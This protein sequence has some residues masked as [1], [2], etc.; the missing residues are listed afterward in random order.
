MK[1]SRDPAFQGA[2]GS[3]RFS[4]IVSSFVFVAAMAAT[5]GTAAAQAVDC[6]RLQAQIASLGRGGGGDPARVQ[7]FQR[8]AQSQQAELDRTV[9]YSR[10]IGCGRRQFLFFGDAA[11]PQCGGLEQQI[12]RMQVNLDQLR[13]QMQRASG[14]DDAQRRDLTARFDAY[15]RGGQP[16]Q[17]AG[18]GLFDTLFGG[19]NS[20]RDVPLEDPSEMPPEDTAPR[21]GSLAICVKTCDG[22]FFPVSYS[23]NRARM[24]EL[25]DLCHALCPN[26]ETQ[27]FTMSLGRDVEQSVSADGRP[28]ASLANAGRFRTKYDST[29]TCKAA[30]QSWV[31]A[32]SNA[33]KLLGRD[34]RR[35]QIVTPERAAELSR[36]QAPAPAKVAGKVDPRKAPKIDESAAEEAAGAQAPTASKESAGIAIGRTTSSSNFS[37]GDGATRETTGPDGARKKVRTVGPLL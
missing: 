6:G 16:Q 20:T 23:A 14:S 35:D 37:L 33:E 3:K 31:E 15:C 10:S 4:R 27:V 18:R 8:A 12:S 29:C 25:G 2:S 36:P 9:S 7:Q 5:L 22:S 30:N 11:P 28:Y 13:G 1:R 21:G 17:Q 24:G 32:L 26:A 34:S 19:G